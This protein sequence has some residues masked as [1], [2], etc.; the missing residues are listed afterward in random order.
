MRG[1]DTRTESFTDSEEIAHYLE[2]LDESEGEDWGVLDDIYDET[3][4]EFFPDTKDTSLEKL[5]VQYE[6][7]GGS[8]Y[9]VVL[10]TDEQGKTRSN[11]QP[12]KDKLAKDILEAL[13]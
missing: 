8:E 12:V 10:Y 2:G 9:Q 7:N 4:N 11:W 6:Q 13:G 1:G 3:S 5:T